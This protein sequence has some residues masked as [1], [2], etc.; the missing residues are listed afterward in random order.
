MLRKIRLTTAIVFFT[1]LT[2]LFLDFTGTLHNWFGW[3]AKIQFVPAILA[4]NVGVVLFL[5]ILTLV[6]GRIYCSVICPLGVFQDIIAWVGKKR[7]KLPYSYSPALSWLRYTVLAL[8]IVALVAGISSFAALLEPYSAF[9]RI[10]NNLF[11]P[12]WQ[13]GNNLLAYLAERAGSYA[14]Y[15]VDVWMKGLPIFVVAVAT[16]VILF[17]LAWKNGRTYCNTICPVGTVLGFVSRFSLFR[18]A[19][20]E[21]KCNNCSLCSRNCKASCIDSKEYKVDLSRCVACGNC[22]G[23]CKRGA[24][25]YKWRPLKVE[26][27]K[28][29]EDVQPVTQEQVSEARRSFFA[30]SALMATTSILKAQEKGDGGLAVIEDKKIPK[31]NTPIVPAG[32]QSIRNM[33]QHC[34]ACQLCVSVCPNR[35]LRP[36]NNLKNLMQPEMSYE[37]GYCRPECTKCSEVCPTGSI[38]RITTADKSSTQI[39]HA[40]WIKQNCVV[41]SDKVQCGNCARHCP[42]DAILMVAIDAEDEKSLKIPVVNTERC[43]GCGACEN[44]CPSRPFSAIYVEGHE[45]HRII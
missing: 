18:I 31:R 8:F 7:K 3:M 22:I 41:V 2:L 45:R 5:V 19:I 29:V 27:K 17:V 35:V 43:I 25:N 12:L 6:F 20:D 26:S 21:D 24:I 23:K 4:L 9:G 42:A 10:A 32:A 44:L 1:L 37:I 39:G 34:T 33:T 40:V 15:E 30:L 36:S 11:A 28:K 13:W 16:L 14:F 38:R